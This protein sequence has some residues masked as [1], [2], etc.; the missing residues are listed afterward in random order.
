MK[1]K[2]ASF[3]QEHDLSDKRS[4]V[5]WLSNRGMLVGSRYM[6]T[7]EDWYADDIR[8]KITDET[9]H[10][11]VLPNLSLYKT[12][13]TALGFIREGQEEDFSID[14]SSFMRQTIRD[15]MRHP[16]YNIEVTFH[17]DYEAILRMWLD[18]PTSLWYNA[19]WKRSAFRSTLS[20]RTVKEENRTIFEYL[21]GLVRYQSGEEEEVHSA[22]GVSLSEGGVNVRSSDP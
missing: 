14:R 5:K 11:F 2:F 16:D 8:N 21:T 3:I 7:R 4:V 1:S 12:K 18:L 20:R 6:A 15:F 17:S 9:D 19:I 10:D 22:Y 13:L